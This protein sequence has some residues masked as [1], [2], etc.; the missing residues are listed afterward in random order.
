MKKLFVVTLALLIALTA[1][2]PAF[3]KGAPRGTFTL[4]ATISAIDPVSGAVTVSVLKGNKLA[5]P[6]VN[7]SLVMSTTAK[8]RYLYKSSATA[9]PTA[10]TFA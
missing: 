10:I 5:Q 4:V 6:Y 1:V 9:V 2:G 3:A 7:Q 8:T